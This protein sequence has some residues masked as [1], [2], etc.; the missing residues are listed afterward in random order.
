M[1]LN[2]EIREK[3]KERG[4]KLW[5]IAEVLN[6]NDGNFSRKLRKELPLTEKQ[7]ILN[8]IDEIADKKEN[9][10]YSATNTING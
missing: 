2:S 7:A 4:V 3:A 8:I 10:V 9:A 6:I 5:E 1:K